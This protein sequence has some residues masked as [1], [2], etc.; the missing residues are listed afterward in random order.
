MDSL[1][2]CIGWKI[3]LLMSRCAKADSLKY[4]KIA[5]ENHV[6]LCWTE[7][8]CRFIF[9]LQQAPKRTQNDYNP[10]L[11][12]FIEFFL[13]IFFVALSSILIVHYNMAFT[14]GH[15]F[16][17]PIYYVA[18]IAGMSFEHS[19]YLHSLQ[20]YYSN[21]F[22]FACLQCQRHTCPGN[23]L[24]ERIN[25]IKSFCPRSAAVSSFWL[26]SNWNCWLIMSWGIQM[27]FSSGFAAY[28]SVSVNANGDKNSDFIKM[29]ALFHYKGRQ[30]FLDMEIYPDKYENHFRKKLAIVSTITAWTRLISIFKFGF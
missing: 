23:F 26:K 10:R 20:I 13:P 5:I 4:V 28:Q 2:F 30:W 7:K 21:R 16:F 17:L 12:W 18:C 6:A 15:G 27:V 1:S 11:M 24:W 29:N 3:H 22:C 19:F 8:S 14:P 9:F 25:F